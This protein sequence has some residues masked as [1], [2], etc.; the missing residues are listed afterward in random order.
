MTVPGLR[1]S[2]AWGQYGT[3]PPLSLV[4]CQQPIPSDNRNLNPAHETNANAL[5]EGGFQT[6]RFLQYERLEE[7]C[8]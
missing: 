6:V 8:V 1:V 4:R 3:V 7:V 2:G 5:S